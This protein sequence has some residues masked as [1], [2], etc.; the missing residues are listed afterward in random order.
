MP[1]MNGIEASEMIRKFLE[2]EKAQQPR[3]VGITGHVTEKFKEEGTKA[4]V[5]EIVPKPMQYK[6]LEE[7]ITQYV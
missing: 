1:V 3:I 4:G 2:H 7:L 5:D 6:K